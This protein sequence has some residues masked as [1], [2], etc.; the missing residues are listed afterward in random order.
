[1]SEATLRCWLVWSLPV[2]RFLAIAPFW[3]PHFTIWA[4][5]RLPAN[6]RFVAFSSGAQSARGLPSLGLTTLPVGVLCHKALFDAY[7][8]DI[9]SSRA[10]IAEAISLAEELKDMYSLAM[11]LVHQVRDWFSGVAIKMGRRQGAT[12]EHI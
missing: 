2:E 5:S 3:H 11:T 4:I 1:M 10:T 12:K 9:T 8:G 7:F 6:T